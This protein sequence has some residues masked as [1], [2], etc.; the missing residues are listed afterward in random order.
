[1]IRLLSVATVIVAGVALDPSQAADEVK[2]AQKAAAVPADRQG[3]APMAYTLETPIARMVLIR[4]RYGTDVL[5]GLEKAIR[6]RGIRNAVIVGGFGSLVRYHV[7][8]VTTQVL[9]PTSGFAKVDRPQDVL[10]VSGYV[11]DGRLHPHITVADETK[12]AG[13][14][15]EPGTEVLTFLNVAL[16]VLP[17]DVRLDRFDDSTWK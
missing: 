5:E 15:V 7:H 6:D 14:H 4:L 16:A 2:A 1:M 9:P 11:I 10:N 8:V 3:E 12:A 17:D 13:G